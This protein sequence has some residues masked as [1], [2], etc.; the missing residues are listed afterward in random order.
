MIQACQNEARP[1]P[2]QCESPEGSFLN[3]DSI[4]WGTDSLKDAPTTPS[5]AAIHSDAAKVSQEDSKHIVLH[6]ENCALMCATVHGGKADR[7]K[8]GEALTSVLCNPS[9]KAKINIHDLFTQASGK[10]NQYQIPEFR[11]TLRKPLLL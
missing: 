5:N 6:A 9:R 4:G 10:T 3:P 11:S 1:R 2:I 7:G 8:F